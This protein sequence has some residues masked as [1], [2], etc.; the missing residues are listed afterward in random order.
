MRKR[1]ARA[2]AVAVARIGLAHGV[3]ALQHR[4]ALGHAFNEVVL[5]INTLP[6][7][8]RGDRPQ[9]LVIARRLLNGTLG[10]TGHGYANVFSACF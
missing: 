4:H 8:L 3:K 10:S 7:Y 2:V 6:V 5:F 1:P 9:G